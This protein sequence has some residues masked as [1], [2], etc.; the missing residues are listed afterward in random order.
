M[1][2]SLEEIEIAR[3][4]LPGA[5]LYVDDALG[6]LR[7][8]QQ[9]FHGIFAQDVIQQLPDE[10]LLGW[11]GACY[12]ALLPG[13]FFCCRVPKA[14]NVMG[15]YYVTMTLHTAGALRTIPCCN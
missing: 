10:L 13:G 14:A 2:R 6:F 7:K 8:Y 11:L 12:D 3:R 5:E 9:T 4:A 15:L 1:D